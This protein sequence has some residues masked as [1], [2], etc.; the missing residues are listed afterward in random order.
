M[1]TN[2]ISTIIILGAISGLGEAFTYYYHRQGKK[3]LAVGCNVSKL[4]S[5][6]SEL[7]GI[8]TFRIDVE[9]IAN[10]ESNIRA[11]I[12]AFLDL[13]AIFVLS[14]IKKF[15]NFK[16]ASTSSNADII[17]EVTTHLTAPLI[18]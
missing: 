17:S 6:K 14:C 16:D 11:V 2:D 1:S 12:K 9:D 5:L 7:K 15:F 3:V 10:L 13:D 18:I 4:D 8:E